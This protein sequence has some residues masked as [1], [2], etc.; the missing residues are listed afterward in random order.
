MPSQ[1][2]SLLQLICHFL[3]SA[4]NTKQKPYQSD[5]WGRCSGDSRTVFLAHVILEESGCSRSWG[6]A[7]DAPV[8]TGHGPKAQR[9]F[10][11]Q[12]QSKAVI[13]PKCKRLEPTFG[14]V[15]LRAVRRSTVAKRRHDLRQQIVHSPRFLPPKFGL[16]VRISDKICLGRSEAERFIKAFVAN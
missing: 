4:P 8:Q 11:I 5:R 3:S 14:G 2:N 7:G 10:S 13:K 16:K 12:P 9:A 15:A 6:D 1:I